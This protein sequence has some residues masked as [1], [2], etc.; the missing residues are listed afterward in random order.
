M[1]YFLFTAL[2]ALT[3]VALTAQTGTLTPE[4]ISFFKEQEQKLRIQ[5]ESMHKGMLKSDRVQ[6][7]AEF[8]PLLVNTLKEKNSFEKS[9]A[10]STR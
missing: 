1:R 2:L 3:T 7:N 4:Q 5:H 9:I 6:R 10:R 8:I